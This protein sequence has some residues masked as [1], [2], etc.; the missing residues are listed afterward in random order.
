M[1]RCC[2]LETS[3]PC[4][5]PQSPKVCS[6]RDTCTPMFIAALFIITRTWK[7]PRCPSADEWIR[8]LW[9]IYTMECYSAIKNNSFELVLMRWMKL[10]PIVQC[11]VSQKDKEQIDSLRTGFVSGALWVSWKE[12]KVLAIQ[13]CL[14]LC[15]PM[16]PASSVHGI[17]PARILEWV[18]IP[19]SRGSSQPKD[20]THVSWITGRFFTVWAMRHLNSVYKMVIRKKEREKE[21]LLW[22]LPHTIQ[23]ESEKSKFWWT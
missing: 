4:L 14:T 18:I 1:F 16:D 7:Q 13:F 15:D 12:V 5:L 20:L 10:E 9:Y 17:F 23:D 22:L 11:E 21:S 6:V 2:S 3:H 19:F 8:K